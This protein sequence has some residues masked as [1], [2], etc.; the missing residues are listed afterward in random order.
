M[1]LP[2]QER[3]YIGVRKGNCPQMDASS[4]SCFT[5]I[6]VKFFVTVVNKRSGVYDSLTDIAPYIKC[7]VVI[8][9]LDN[10]NV[11]IM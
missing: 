8:C 11:K 5:C 4:P 1:S 10:V 6:F 3:S 2:N 7:I 9:S